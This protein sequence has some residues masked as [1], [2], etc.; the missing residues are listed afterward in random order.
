MHIRL[1]SLY[2]ESC[3]HQFLPAIRRIYHGCVQS[4]R[5]LR[6]K[7]LHWLHWQLGNGN[8]SISTSSLIIWQDLQLKV[9]PKPC[10]LWINTLSTY[11]VTIYTEYKV[12]LQSVENLWKL[13]FPNAFR[14]RTTY[15]MW[16]SLFSLN[17]FQL[18]LRRIKCYTSSALCAKTTT[19]ALAFRLCTPPWGLI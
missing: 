2:A 7:K 17:P 6:R 14:Q 15:L 9:D 8:G 3:R 12:S 19:S 16:T 18:R 1:R 4:S 11:T 5:H 10:R 13:F